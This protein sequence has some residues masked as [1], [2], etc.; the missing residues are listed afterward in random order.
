MA[1]LGE[2]RVIFFVSSLIKIRMIVAMHE[3][4]SMKTMTMVRVFFMGALL[5]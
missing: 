5:H 4:K 3:M 1:S 2:E